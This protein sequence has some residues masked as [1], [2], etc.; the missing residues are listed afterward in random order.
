VFSLASAASKVPA[1]ALR[2]ARRTGT[3]KLSGWIKELPLE[4]CRL[5]NLRTLDL[6]SNELSALPPEIGRLINLRK[7]YLAGN[8]L[9]ALPPEICQLANI[10]ELWLTTN[11]FTELPPEVCRLNT[12]EDLILDNNYLT[13]LTPEIGQLTNLQNLAIYCNGLLEVPPEIGRLIEL[14]KLDLTLNKLTTLPPEIGQLERLERLLLYVNKLTSLPAEIGQLASLQHLDLSDNQLTSLPAEIGQLASLQHLDLS[15]NRLTSLRAEIADLIEY[16]VTI[17]LG[18]NPL[19]DPKGVLRKRDK[20]A[21]LAYI[22]GM[23]ERVQQYEVKMILVGD[24]GVGKTS[25]AAALAGSPFIEGRSP[26]HGIEIMPLT[27]LEPETETEITVR[28]WDFGGQEAYRIT[29]QFFCTRRALYLVVWNARSG[30]KQDDVVGWIRKISLRVS[31]DAR[32]LVVAT[33]CDEYQPDLNYR[34]LKGLFPELLA[35]YCEVDNRTGHGIGGLRAKIAAEVASLPQT[36]KPISVRWAS[37]RQEILDLAKSEPQLSFSRF[38]SIC[39][40]HQV[41]GEEIAALANLMHD[42]GQVIY[43]GDDERLSDLVVLNPEWLSQAIS[44]VLG[45]T[46]TREAGGVLDHARLWKIWGGHAEHLGYREELYPYFLRL[47]EKFDVSYRLEEA[48]NRSLIAQLVSHERPDLP[49]RTASTLPLGLRQLNLVCQFDECPLG[50]IAWLTVRHHHAAT[51]KHWHSGVF[52]RHPIP[53]YASEALIELRHPTELGLTVRAPSPDLFFNVL[54]DSIEDLLT[55]RWPGLHYELHVPCPTMHTDDCFC[56][57]TF[58]FRA[59]LALRER[60]QTGTVAC[61]QCGEVHEIGRLL[62]GFQHTVTPMQPELDRLLEGLSEVR[63]GISRLEGYAAATADAIRRLLTIASTEITDCPRLFTLTPLKVQGATRMAPWQRRYELQLWC[64]HPGYWH[65]WPQATYRMERPKEW[66]AR[67]APYAV[68]I[69]RALQLAAPLAASVAGLALTPEQL[70]NTQGKIQLMSTLIA[71]MPDQAP[72][73]P[74][75]PTAEG[76]ELSPAQG[77]AARTL[78]AAVFELDP[79]QAFGDLRRV[80]TP[81]GELLWVCPNHYLSYDPGLPAMARPD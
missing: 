39:V 11:R 43:Y 13:K 70:Q 63:A 29:H 26:T 1:D 62:T 53:A 28:V 46:L 81:S 37:A 23:S 58:A 6:M 41:E 80:H 35:G 60:G 56:S 21:W 49:W 48:G 10:S 31:G 17:E 66:L 19:A 73:N 65:A 40:D 78:R 27:V 2:Q 64:E 54:R 42:L 34:Y 22:R 45:D 72:G 5:T 75:I 4:V 61:L 7:L 76:H 14:Q 9:T 36:G 69:V 16:G 38:S 8:H 25:L 33:H 20:N 79:G 30:H 44:L 18:G 50:L 67:I 12:L 74:V 71:A 15:Q 77:Q 47:M 3:L 52:L 68:F 24:G 51:G 57:G 55:S 59:L 32:V